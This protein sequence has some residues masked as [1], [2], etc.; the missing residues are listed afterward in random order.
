M[1]EISRVSDSEKTPRSLREMQG[2]VLARYQ[3]SHYSMGTIF[4]ITAYG[5]SSNYV[6]Q[7]V[8]QAFQEIDR[9]NGTMS[10][11]RPD[12]E[13]SIINREAFGRNVAVTPELFELLQESFRLS[14]ETAGTFD[15]TVGQLM[16]SW[17]FFQEGERVPSQVELLDVLKRTG[18]H[19]VKLD[20]ETRSIRFDEPGIE[21]DL[22]AIGKGYAVD[23]V[24]EILRENGIDCALVSSGTS[25]IYALGA[26]P[27][28]KGWEISI[29][30]PLDRRKQACSF[31][32]RDLSVSISGIH[33]KSFALDGRLYTHI[34]NPGDGMPAGKML[35]SVVVT[36]SS[37]KSDA[38]S[39]SFFA[40][41]PDMSRAYLAC[42][43]DAA[44][45]LYVRNDS[46]Y[47]FEEIILQSAVNPLPDDRIVY[48]GDLTA[49]QSCHN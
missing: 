26:P 39:T 49:A 9:L 21:L 30:H 15:I 40:G 23:R 29:C 43:P 24:I 8:R 46:S 2:D 34:L 12:S 31:Q 22:G 36:V 33:E 41:G 5:A 7:V 3:S 6:E 45:I 28:Q 1:K 14:E 27:G 38:L 13:L 35:M 17:G 20:S 48:S 11:Y 25:S 47:S 42:H 10:H 16:K 37:T 19:H 44:A 4:S 18:F 32:L